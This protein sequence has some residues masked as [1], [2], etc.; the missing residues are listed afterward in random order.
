MSGWF[1]ALGQQAAGQ[2]VSGGIAMGMQ[3]LGARYDRKQQAKSARQMMGIQMEGEREM[4][5]YQQQKQLEMWEKTGPQ[6]MKAQLK[7]AGLNPALMYGMGGGGG[8]TV[9]GGV[10]SVQGTSAPYVDTTTAATGMGMQSAKTIAELQV[11]QAQKENIEADTKNKLAGNPNIGLEGE[12]IQAKTAGQNIANDIA[13][14]EKKLKSKTLDYNI[15]TA[16]EQWVKIAEERQILSNVRA[17][18]GTDGETLIE[19]EKAKLTK[20]GVEIALIEATKGKTDKEVENITS[21]IT[22]RIKELEQAGD[23]IKIDQ[24]LADWETSYGKQVAGLLGNVINLIPGLTKKPP[25][26]KGQKK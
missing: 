26:Q 3:R 10:P 9:G 25:V 20:L 22:T 19:T 13:E 16:F 18:Q 15:D 11:M 7:A 1:A 14:L 6:G 12:N 24:Q 8:Q 17:A 5:N 2:A 23:R 4:M 21:Q